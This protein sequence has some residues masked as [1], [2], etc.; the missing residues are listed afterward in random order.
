M[1]TAISGERVGCSKKFKKVKKSFEARLTKALSG[2]RDRLISVVEKSGLISLPSPILQKV[3]GASSDEIGGDAKVKASGVVPYIKNKLKDRAKQLK[4]QIYSLPQQLH[5]FLL[6]DVSK[7]N[8]GSCRPRS[9]LNPKADAAVGVSV[10]LNQHQPWSG[11][12]KI[13]MN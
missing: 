4:L 6:G 7:I 2:E 8:P 9:K 5:Q 13:S 10:C 1:P 11:R 3:L 12:L